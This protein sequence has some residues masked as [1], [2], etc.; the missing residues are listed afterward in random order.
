MITSLI[1]T[2]LAVVLTFEL[3]IP[4]YKA[5]HVDQPGLIPRNP[6]PWP[7]RGQTVGYIHAP[8]ELS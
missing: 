3:P 1:T 5:A 4:M 6:P 7:W 2:D 8:T